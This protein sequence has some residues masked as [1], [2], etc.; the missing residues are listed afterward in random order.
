MEKEIRRVPFDIERAKAG[1]KVVTGYG[2]PVRVCLF[3][4]KN[5]YTPIVAAVEIHGVETPFTFTKE[6]R[7]L[8]DTGVDDNL[9]LFIEEE[10]VHPKFK[11]DD[12]MRLLVEAEDDI[13][14][15]LPVVVSIDDKYYHCNNETIAIKDQ[16][17]YEFPPMNAKQKSSNEV[18]PNS[19]LMTLQELSDWL[20]D[21]PEEHR[22]YK[23]VDSST[24]R[25]SYAYREEDTSKLADDILV[26][27]NHGEWE[28]PLI[29]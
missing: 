18:K 1:A 11:V 6:G 9:G 27:R 2:Y 25:N 22:E 5:K 8:V 20:R 23:Y 17:D 3:D 29:K 7:L 16:D 4:L 14:E 26:R 13:T 19:R 15:G 24:V 10:V 28:E 21:S 12:V